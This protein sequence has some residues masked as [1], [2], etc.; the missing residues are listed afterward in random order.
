MKCKNQQHR[1]RFRSIPFS[2]S[3]VRAWQ[4]LVGT[5]YLPNQ[6]SA[7]STSVPMLVE[8]DPKCP[9]RGAAAV[10]PCPACAYDVVILMDC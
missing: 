8:G 10:D 5:L 6:L 9:K 1:S 7:A 3:V 2:I 4:F